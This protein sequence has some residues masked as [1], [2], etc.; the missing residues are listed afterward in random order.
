MTV[1][2]RGRRGLPRI[3]R[4]RIRAR[5]RRVLCALDQSGSELSIFLV[6]D[7]SIAALNATY[8]GIEGATDVLSF[9]LVEGVHADRRGELLGDVI[10]SLET[11]AR[12]ARRARRSLEDQVLRLL[13]HGTLHL[14]GHDHEREAEARAM[15]AEER[16]VWRAVRA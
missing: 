12:Q 5:A 2:L 9:S 10:V 1:R 15:A 3:D 4:A 8:R 6:D 7:A 14:L 11:A 16:R 13:I